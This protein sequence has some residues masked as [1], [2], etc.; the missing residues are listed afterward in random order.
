MLKP[1]RRQSI[2]KKLNRFLAE[3]NAKTGQFQ[4]K[5]GRTGRYLY[6]GRGRGQFVRS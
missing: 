3:T 1:L 5:A 4:P 6:S 2:I